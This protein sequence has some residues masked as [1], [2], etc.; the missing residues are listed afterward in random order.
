MPFLFRITGLATSFRE[1]YHKYMMRMEKL[2]I[3][4][5]ILSVSVQPSAISFQLVVRI[6]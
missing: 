3:T 4:L 1:L 5:A 6:Q 2:I